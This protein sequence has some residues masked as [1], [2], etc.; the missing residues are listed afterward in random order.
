MSR[1]YELTYHQLAYTR[2]TGSDKGIEM[3][4]SW[5]EID[6]AAGH[7]E[8]EARR[9]QA[10]AEAE[11]LELHLASRTLTVVAWEA[12]QQGR[13]VQL[14]WVGGELSGVPLAAVGDLVVMRTDEGAAGVNVATLSSVETSEQKV[15]D[16]LVG[17]RTVESFVAWCRMVQ[18]RPVHVSVLGGRTVDGVL[19]AVAPD[20][21]MVRTRL[22]SDVAVTRSEV[23]AVSVA[24]D[25]FLAV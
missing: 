3:P 7:V 23:A 18:G 24:G 4:D 11:A 20:H 19:V 13:R 10:A 1:Y 22:G 16:G 6:E 21:L 14:R 8:R 25:A 12:M 2:E 17:D 5:D 15:D 9:E